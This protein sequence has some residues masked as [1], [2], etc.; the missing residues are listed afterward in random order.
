MFM[1][2]RKMS[3]FS[4]VV[5]TRKIVHQKIVFQ[6][7]F[8]GRKQV[9]QEKFLVLHSRSRQTLKYILSSRLVKTGKYHSII[10][11]TESP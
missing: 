7:L 8:Q 10:N 3:G 6:F 9:R 1:S 4:K 5:I 2:D 11:N